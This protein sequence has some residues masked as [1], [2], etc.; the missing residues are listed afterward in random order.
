[1]NATPTAK[2]R[3]RR[4]EQGRKRSTPGPD[5]ILQ[6]RYQT[7]VGALADYGPVIDAWLVDHAPE[8]W[9]RI[10]EKDDELFRLRRM[11]VPVH[12]Y[13]AK[14]QSFL[15]LCEQAE[16]SY[17]EAKPSELSLPPLAEDTTVAVYY[18]LADGSLHKANNTDE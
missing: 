8:V 5:A 13:E 6:Q 7:E 3:H 1:M 15:E 16:Q 11:G 10:H 2:Q 18:E 4:F 9:H 17:Y 14:L 12:I